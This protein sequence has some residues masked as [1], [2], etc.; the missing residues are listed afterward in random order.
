[1]APHNPYAPPQ[2]P[3][4]SP[5]SPSDVRLFSAGAIATHAV[6]LTPLVGAILAALNHHRLGNRPAVRRTSLTFII[7]SA[8]L[9]VILLVAGARSPGLLRIVTF[10]WS[11]SVARMLY[12]EHQVLFQ[13]HVD[14]GGKV[15]RWYLATLATL[16]AFLVVVLVVAVAA[17]FA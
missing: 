8:L 11:I 4:A 15:A 6:V 2:T 12:Q 17:T 14:A 13:K 1:M 16:G 3:P 9:L 7:P 10:V 5:R